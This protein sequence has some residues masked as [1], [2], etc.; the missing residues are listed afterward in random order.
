MSEQFDKNCELAARLMVEASKW[1]YR[2]DAQ[3]LVEA[4]K[5]MEDAAAALSVSSTAAAT[6]VNLRKWEACRAFL[7]KLIAFYEPLTPPKCRGLIDGWG[8][9][10][11]AD[12]DAIDA[13]VAPSATTRREDGT[14]LLYNV[15]SMW[16]QETQDVEWQLQWKEVLAAIDQH[17]TRNNY[18]N[19]APS[20]LPSCNDIGCQR[21]GER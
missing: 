3:A 9:Q 16:L 7:S 14:P 6:D 20:I 8:K 4:G 19:A 15:H 18:P 12:L 10:Y 5:L 17:L 13:T 2:T 1:K 21:E 11:N